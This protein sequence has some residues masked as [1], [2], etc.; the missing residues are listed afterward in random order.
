PVNGSVNNAVQLTCAVNGSTPPASCSV[1]PTSVTLA[2]TSAT[3]TLKVT[4]PSPMAR[5]M[6]ATPKLVGNFYAAFLI[7]PSVALIGL[8]FPGHKPTVRS[9]QFWLLCS[10][11]IVSIVLHAGCGGG[12][13][14]PPPPPL[15]YTVTV[16]ATSGA[17]QH[18]TQVS[19]TVP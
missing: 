13:S 1:S 7:L 16:T 19:V 2:A 17:I 15:N 4:A 10:V 5:L 8:G 6:P 12:S 11:F 3:T 18:T 14:N 9:R